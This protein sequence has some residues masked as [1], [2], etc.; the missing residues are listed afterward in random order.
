MFSSGTVGQAPKR[1]PVPARAL[2][3]SIVYMARAVGLVTATLR[4]VGRPGWAS[5]CTMRFS[6][7]AADGPRYPLQTPTRLPLK[8]P[9]TDPQVQKLQILRRRPRAY[10]F[11]KS[12]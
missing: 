8:A 12:E 6:G 4:N 1:C 2:L 11:V 5:V 7:A 9:T 10:R 3:S